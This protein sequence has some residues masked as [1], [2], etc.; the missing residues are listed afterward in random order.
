MKVT[1]WI[2]LRSINGC[3]SAV[4]LQLFLQIYET[5]C[6]LKWVKGNINSR[7]TKQNIILMSMLIT[8]TPHSIY[9]SKV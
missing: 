9:Q 4:L 1:L 3:D 7:I 5:L 8:S 2:N 6:V